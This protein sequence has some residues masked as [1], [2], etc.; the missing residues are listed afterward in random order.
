MRDLLPPELVRLIRDRYLAGVADAE[1]QFSMH[2][3]DEDTVTGA[4]GQAISMSH[5]QIFQS[6]GER[7]VWQVSYKKIRGRGKG[8]P[9]F[10]LGADGMFQIEVR[11]RRNRVVRR[12]GLPFQ[13]KKF[14]EGRDQELIGQAEKI[15]AAAGQ[16]LVIAFSDVRYEACSTADVLRLEGDGRRV[17]E[18]RKMRSLG[19]VL[20]NDFLNCDIGTDGLYYDPRGRRFVKEGVLPGMHLIT[21]EVRQVVRPVR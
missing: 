21:T 12:K 2:Q 13:A 9:E 17:R 7:Y 19:Q 6:N 11:D 3:E 1:A 16:G 10:H 4:L 8:A 20:G 15:N 14:W 18:E 5:P